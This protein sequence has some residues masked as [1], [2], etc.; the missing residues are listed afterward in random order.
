MRQ[1]ND[2]S[3]KKKYFELT[4]HVE[5]S[6]CWVWKAARIMR[7]RKSKEDVPHPVFWISIPGQK[8]YKSVYARRWAYER[9]HGPIPEEHVVVNVC[10][11][12]LCVRPDDQHN[13]LIRG[14]NKYFDELTRDIV[15]EG[16]VRHTPSEE[17]FLRQK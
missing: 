11:N 7:R 3:F 2:E 14:S 10:G 15:P 9:T 16:R 4:F 12:K 13:T 6:A 1:T 8:E 17:E 5:N